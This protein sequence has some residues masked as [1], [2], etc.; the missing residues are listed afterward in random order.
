MKP[1][2]KM[3]I[4]MDQLAKN[5]RSS[6]NSSTT[7]KSEMKEEEEVKMEDTSPKM[8]KSKDASVIDKR[9]MFSRKQRES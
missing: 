7:K 6:A 4:M 3:S 9:I 8:D 2:S 1:K 5:T